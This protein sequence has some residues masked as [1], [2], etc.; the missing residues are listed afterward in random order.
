MSM[1]KGKN[2]QLAYGDKIIIDGIDLDI[3]KGEVV[4]VI[5]TNGCGKSTL[6]KALS[7]ALPCKNGNIWLEGEEIHSIKN[8]EFA[9]KLAFV[10]QNN[11]IPEDIT[12][13][14]FIMYG[15]VPHK[16]WYELYNDKDREIVEWAVNICRL[17][18]F[19][20]RKVMSLSGG[21]RQKVWIAMVLAQK[22]QVLL[23]DEPTTY[24]D[25]CHQFEIMELVKKLNKEL[26]ITIV[27]V[28]HDLNQA[29]QYSDRIIVVKE[30]K[31][32]REGK[33]LDVLTPQL[34]K[35]V[36]RVEAVMEIEDNIPYFKL[37]GIVN[38]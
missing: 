32:Y 20:D 34:I 36:Y 29:A 30:G 6:L 38:N 16:K 23:L 9:K 26:G 35:D 27:M 31:K 2:I 5:G 8:K 1:I 24:L 19:R 21:E 18:K 13:Y 12:V 37:K 22:T 33:A 17:D 4:S 11:E 3:K 25:I 15:R 14:D 28:L 7:R 10:S